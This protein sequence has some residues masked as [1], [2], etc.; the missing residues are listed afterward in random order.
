MK[1]S[2]QQF[3]SVFAL[4]RYDNSSTCASFSLKKFNLKAFHVNKN[5]I[6]QRSM[7]NVQ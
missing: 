1:V 3:L 2:R 7:F 4:Q 5:T 6:S